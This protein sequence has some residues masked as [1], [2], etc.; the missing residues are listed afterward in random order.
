MIIIRLTVERTADDQGAPFEAG[1]EE[2]KV[3]LNDE[4]TVESLDEICNLISN[5]VRGA[6]G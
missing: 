2:Y 4:V 3:D 6:R 1:L 5:I